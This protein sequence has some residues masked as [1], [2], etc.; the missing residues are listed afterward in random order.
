M[1]SKGLYNTSSYTKQL[2]GQ[3]MGKIISDI[4]YDE[5]TVD[6][7]EHL[8]DY[9]VLFPDISSTIPSEV[10]DKDM[11]AFGQ[12]GWN[13]PYTSFRKEDV[14]CFSFDIPFNR[15][16]NV[17]GVTISRNSSFFIMILDPMSSFMT[18]R[19]LAFLC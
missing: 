16:A 8:V 3:Y 10:S 12:N 13:G 11:E 17:L 5:V 9:K 7:N 1:I 6:I 18:Q 4:G 15:K 2:Q 14:K 19:H